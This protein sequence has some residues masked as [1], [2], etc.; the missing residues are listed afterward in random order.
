MRSLLYYYDYLA[1]ENELDIA[2]QN[3]NLLENIKKLIL[4][5][6]LK[7][8]YMSIHFI[9]AVTLLHLQ[10]KLIQTLHQFLHLLTTHAIK[11]NDI[12]FYLM[13]ITSIMREITSELAKAN[14]LKDNVIA[15]QDHDIKNKLKP[16]IKPKIKNTE[17]ET[18]EE[19]EE[20]VK[21]RP[22]SMFRMRLRSNH[23]KL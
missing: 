15:Q 5:E 16:K 7:L 11:P 19:E 20:K 9:G 8:K 18:D 13:K 21:I 14:R 2:N 3:N 17:K 23:N 10:E 12:R 22:R 6:E 4:K 1:I